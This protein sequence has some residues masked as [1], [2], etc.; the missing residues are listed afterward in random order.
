[1]PRVMIECPETKKEV[2][3]GINLN[4]ETFESY[5]IG[6]NKLPCPQCGKEHEWTRADAL[7]D[8]AGGGA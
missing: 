8:E 1:M 5:R 2:Y 3:T 4:W 6:K 7:L